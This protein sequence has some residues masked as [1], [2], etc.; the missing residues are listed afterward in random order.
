[1]QNQIAGTEQVIAPT[2]EMVRVL[3]EEMHKEI[4]LQHVRHDA[5]ILR[6]GRIGL[7]QTLPLM[8]G[9]DDFGRVEA[10]IPKHRYW[11]LRRKY[12][13]GIFT[14]DDGMKDLKRHH[15]EWFPETVSPRIQVGAGGKWNRVAPGGH[16]RLRRR[17][18][19]GAGTME[20][21]PGRASSP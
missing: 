4:V 17:F 7:P 9:R 12:G 13:R 11:E 5:E 15:P 2:P 1:M 3:C 14:T 21:A 10:F 19:F 16:S 6:R 20:F 8:D 18:R